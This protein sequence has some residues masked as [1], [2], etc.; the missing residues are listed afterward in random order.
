VLDKIYY[1]LLEAATQ[2]QYW[3]SFYMKKAPRKIR[4]LSVFTNRQTISKPAG[5]ACLSCIEH[6]Y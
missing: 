4:A 6:G 2:A 3:G 5:Q 1:G